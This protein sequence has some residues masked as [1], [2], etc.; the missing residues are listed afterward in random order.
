V[1]ATHLAI[2]DKMFD[3]HILTIIKKRKERKLADWWQHMTLIPA[4]KR[5]RQADL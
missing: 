1:L 4:L 2:P 3:P 5:Q